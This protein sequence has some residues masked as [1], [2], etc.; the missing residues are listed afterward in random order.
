MKHIIP[1]T[2]TKRRVI[3]C[4]EDL[5]DKPSELIDLAL[6]D[7][8]RLE[9]TPG[10]RINMETYHDL[11]MADDLCHVCLGGAVLTN[12]MDRDERHRL[13]GGGRLQD[14]IRALD[15]F[16]KGRIEL[17]LDIMGVA[18]PKGLPLDA[19]IALYPH[20]DHPYQGKLSRFH[21]DL[22]ALASTLRA[23]GI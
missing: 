18:H 8:L 4:Y 12:F 13:D 5:P 17:G 15:K 23:H 22:R 6:D 3:T 10:Y 2:H 9:T 7:V 14:K 11:N 21:T 20:A 1:D 16:R 19:E